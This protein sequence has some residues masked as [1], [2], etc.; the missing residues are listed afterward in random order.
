MNADPRGR[1]L[2]RLQVKRLLTRE[3][4]PPCSQYGPSS[5]LCEQEHPHY[6]P[7]FFSV[8][9]VTAAKRRLSNKQAKDFAEPGRIMQVSMYVHFPLLLTQVGACCSVSWP[10]HP[11]IHLASAVLT[12]ALT[13]GYTCLLEPKAAQGTEVSNTL[14]N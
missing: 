11:L 14:D 13:V 5:D 3:C 7:V 2:P 8:L 6:D 12:A 9:A 1:I 10:R 4:N